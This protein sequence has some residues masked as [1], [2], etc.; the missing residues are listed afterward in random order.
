M[1]KTNFKSFYIIIDT[2]TL[3][4]RLCK[5]K[6]RVADI[7]EMHR[8]SINIGEKPIIRGNLRISKITEE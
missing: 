3:E 7:L 4:A 6:Q 5:T 8:N 1:K 2:S